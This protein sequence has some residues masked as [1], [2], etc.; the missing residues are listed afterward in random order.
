MKVG[1]PGDLE[2]LHSHQGASRLEAGG[3]LAFHSV[4]RSRR[5]LRRE[6]QA[7]VSVLLKFVVLAVGDVVS[8]PANLL[9]GRKVFAR[10]YTS[11]STVVWYQFIAALIYIMPK[12]GRFLPKSGQV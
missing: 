6:Q 4:A 1:S 7:E 2:N 3:C 5:R 9:L 10:D 11:M 12:I 8:R